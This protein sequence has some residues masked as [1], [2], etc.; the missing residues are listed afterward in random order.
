M[1]AALADIKD[2][3]AGQVPDHLRD[4]HYQGAEKLQRGVGYQYPHNYPDG[5]VNQTYLPDTLINTHYYQPKDTGRYEQAL[6]Q[7][8]NE[9]QKRK[10]E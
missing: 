10:Q 2:G 1:D 4:S 3:K 7:R 9:L 6:H 5:W 8:L